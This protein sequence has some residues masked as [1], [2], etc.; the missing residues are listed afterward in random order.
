MNLLDRNGNAVKPKANAIVH[1][2]LTRPTPHVEEVIDPGV[3]VTHLLG[4]G[5]LG[6][7]TCRWPEAGQ[8]AGTLFCGQ[9][10]MDGPYRP[11]HHRKAYVTL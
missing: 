9:H 1:R 11:T 3:D 10:T 5:K 8:G 2:V 4:I 6:Q 7:H